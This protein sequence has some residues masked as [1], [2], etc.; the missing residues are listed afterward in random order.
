MF[1]VSAFLLICVLGIVVATLVPSRVRLVV[2]TA[3]VVAG[4][5][6]WGSWA[7]HPHVDR[8]EW[9]PFSTFVRPRDIVLNVLLYIPVGAF[10]PAAR[11]FRGGWQFIAAAVLYGFTLSLV[12]EATQVFSHRR[13][14]GMTDIVTNTAGAAIGA[15]LAVWRA[16][17]P[18]GLRS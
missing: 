10:M 16:A 8:I 9:V 11:R 15:L 6:P 1:G 5:V 4:V 12:T 3:I 13:Y 2:W 18:A 17:A 14:P 7:G